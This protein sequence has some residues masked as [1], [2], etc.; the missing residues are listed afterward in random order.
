M[1]NSYKISLTA[2]LLALVFLSQNVIQGQ[3]KFKAVGFDAGWYSPS[4]KFWNEETFIKNWDDQHSGALFGRG[5]IEIGLFK[6]VNSRIGIGYWTHTIKESGIIWGTETRT[7]ELQITL[8]PVTMDILM[9]FQFEDLEPVGFYGGLGWGLNIIQM[10][11]TRIPSIS[12]T[13]VDDLSGRDYF[14]YMLAGVNIPIARGY[15]VAV[16]GR[17]ILGQYIQQLYSY[18]TIR[19]YDVSLSGPQFSVILKYMLDYSIQ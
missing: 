4:L 18:N 12:D 5:F 14:G 16:E 17:Y 3:V 2:L 6:S 8:I 19:D 10:E 1:K 15:T 13:T 11:F 9:E 7:D